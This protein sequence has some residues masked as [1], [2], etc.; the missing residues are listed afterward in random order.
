MHIKINLQKKIN[1]KKKK[2]KKDI[3]KRLKMTNAAVE[4]A[5]TGDKKGFE[6][7]ITEQ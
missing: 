6:Q 5:K 1:C 7:I 2:K 3:I 4:T